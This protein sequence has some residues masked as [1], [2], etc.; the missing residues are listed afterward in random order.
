MRKYLVNV[1]GASYE[2]EVEEITGAP[3]A[4]PAPAA[5]RTTA[6]AAAASASVSAPTTAESAGLPSA[7]NLV[8]PMPGNI[9]AVNV[10]VGD[11]VT[12]GQTLV[13]LEAMKMENE[14][15]AP[16]AGTIKAINVNVGMTVNTGDILL[17]IG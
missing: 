8:A 4:M 9:L 12:S 15:L 17:V 7:N 5:T 6:P 11:Q 3:G 2:I 13:M 16:L 14:I 1:N 10:R